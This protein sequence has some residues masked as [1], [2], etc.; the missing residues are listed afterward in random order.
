[1]FFLMIFKLQIR[2]REN[3]LSE[4]VSTE[5]EVN[6]ELRKCLLFVINFFSFF[7]N[8]QIAAYFFVNNF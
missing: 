2:D 3:S 8:L 7:L 1:M 4:P 6:G 5:I